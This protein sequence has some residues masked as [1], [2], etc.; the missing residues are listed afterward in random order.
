MIL[1]VPG[2]TELITNATTVSPYG[3]TVFG[4]LTLTL[5]VANIVQA[6]VVVYLYKGKEKLHEQM[7]VNATE[8]TQTFTELTRF[9]HKASADSAEYQK[10]SED[11]TN[12]LIRI[13]K[14]TGQKL[15]NDEKIDP[16]D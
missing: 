1:Q 13:I 16:D 15:Q 4:F 6:G 2:T 8:Q 11:R 3:E 9:L 5:I 14:R 7:T 12:R 10:A